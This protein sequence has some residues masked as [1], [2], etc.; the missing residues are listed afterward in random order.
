[1]HRACVHVLLGCLA[2]SSALGQ[3][4]PPRA[5]DVGAL[6]PRGVVVRPLRQQVI[7]CPYPA[8][9]VR[10]VVLAHLGALNDCYRAALSRASPQAGRFA[11]RWRIEP[12]GTVSAVTVEPA[13]APASRELHAC[14]ADAVRT[15]RF[16]AEPG[17]GVVTITYPM[18]FAPAVDEQ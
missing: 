8:E 9:V 1:M 4:R 3:R 18:V 5:A 10:R 16:P 15:W 7:A 6:R 13:G 12:D 14:L 2:A 11:L 17:R